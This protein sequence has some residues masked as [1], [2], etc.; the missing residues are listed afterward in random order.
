MVQVPIFSV[1][2]APGQILRGFHLGSDL[3]EPWSPIR[4]FTSVIV[5]YKWSDRESW[6]KYVT[7]PVPDWVTEPAPPDENR[8]FIFH[9]RIGLFGHNNAQL[10]SL[11]IRDYLEQ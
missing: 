6:A 11:D 8:Y 2:Y 5:V 3:G 9:R 4:S 1:I 7:D 10:D